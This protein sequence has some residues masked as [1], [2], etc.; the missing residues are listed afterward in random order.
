MSERYVFAR[1]L[2][3]KR[4]IPAIEVSFKASVNDKGEKILDIERRMIT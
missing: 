4:S 1:G 3:S 2:L